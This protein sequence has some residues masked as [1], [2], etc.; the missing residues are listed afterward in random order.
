M[1]RSVAAILFALWWTFL[2]P[3]C[4]SG[5]EDKMKGPHAEVHR[6]KPPQEDSTSG[7]AMVFL[8]SI[9]FYQKW[10][11]PIGGGNRCGF[12]PS[13]SVYGYSAIKTQGPL[14]GVM[15]TADRLTRCNLW[16]RPGADYFLLP[17]GRLYDPVS[18]NLLSEK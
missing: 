11:S 6:S 8:E 16:K 3:F 18:N 4:A 13:C 17:G 2:F 15:M 7:V 1:P 10:I 12:R 5:S 14:V 9:R